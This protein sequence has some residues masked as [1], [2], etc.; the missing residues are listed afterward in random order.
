MGF[1][2]SSMRLEPKPA[3]AISAAGFALLLIFGAA[4]PGPGLWLLAAALGCIAAAG[5]TWWL[6]ASA[7]ARTRPVAQRVAQTPFS[8]SPRRPRG[9]GVEL[10]GNIGAPWQAAA[11]GRS[12]PRRVHVAAVVGACGLLGLVI[13]IVGAV[14]GDQ[15][16][17]PTTP[18]LAVSPEVIDLSREG[19]T[20]A[21]TAT[22]RPPTT[23]PRSSSPVAAASAA[24]T[25][26]ER[27][28]VVAAP[29]PAT[30]VE[31]QQRDTSVAAPVL[32]V[33][34]TVVDGDT[35][36]EIALTYGSTVDAILTLNGLSNADFIHPGEVL[37]IPQPDPD[38][39]E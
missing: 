28:I 36:Y 37:L 13:F 21:V 34:H 35:L 25:A 39:V 1:A 20:T 2:A 11:V 33:K 23:E 6:D 29:K 26:A 31:L 9:F 19:G 30:P 7:I 32:T 10:P 38:D 3:A 14:G 16:A 4:W 8:T 17:D 18:T 22:V 24:P 27:P 5:A 15:D 12:L